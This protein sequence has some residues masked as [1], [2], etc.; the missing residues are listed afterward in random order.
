MCTAVLP[1]EQKTRRFLALSVGC[2]NKEKIMESALPVNSKK[3]A[4]W[5]VRILAD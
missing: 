1:T 5:A 3:K 2:K 4:K